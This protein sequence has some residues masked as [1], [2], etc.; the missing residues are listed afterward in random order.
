MCERVV[1]WRWGD[2]EGGEGRYYELLSVELYGGA[3]I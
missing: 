2:E 3:W 1:W